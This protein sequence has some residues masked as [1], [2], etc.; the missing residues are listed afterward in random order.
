MPCP[1]R[2]VVEDPLAVD[3]VVVEVAHVAG[4][5]HKLISPGALVSAV[6]PLARVPCARRIAHGAEPGH[7]VVLPLALVDRVAV[8]EHPAPM[9]QHHAV[10]V[11]RLARVPKLFASGENKR[12]VAS[13]RVSVLIV[14]TAA[15]VGCAALLFLLDSVLVL[16]RSRRLLARGILGRLAARRLDRL[17]GVVADGPRALGSGGR[18]RC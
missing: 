18:C 16:A 3:L 7:C 15:T 5:A 8:P 4:A 1:P 6:E 17:L 9:A 2:L 11:I 13:E 12:P 10:K 14:A